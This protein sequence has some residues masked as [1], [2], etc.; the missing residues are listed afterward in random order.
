VKESKEHSNERTNE[1]GKKGKGIRHT[2][3]V[4]TEK[5]ERR[6]VRW[7]VQVTQKEKTKKEN[8]TRRN[9][10]IVLRCAFF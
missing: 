9:N 6:S 7:K 8:T 5:N 2:S 10:V 1:R 4:E 3:E